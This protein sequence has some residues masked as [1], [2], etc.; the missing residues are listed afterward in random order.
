MMKKAKRNLFEE[1]KE[2]IEEIKSYQQG[3]ITLKE[4]HIK[5]NPVPPV[6][7]KLIRDLREKLH[8]SRG[9]FAMR[10]RVSPR[11]L[12][13]WEQGITKPND[14]AAALILMVKKYPV[15]FSYLSNI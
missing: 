6:S 9:V 3:K 15:T 1:L 12:E 5:R 10:L 8:L 11:T 4:Y 14:Q 13:K 2:G 7:P